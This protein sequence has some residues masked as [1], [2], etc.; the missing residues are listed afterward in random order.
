MAS[1]TMALAVM[2]VMTRTATRDGWARE[3]A[4]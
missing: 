4:G 3:Y 2:V 1:A